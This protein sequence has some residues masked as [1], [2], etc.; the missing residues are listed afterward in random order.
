M[1]AIKKELN[2][3][4]VD[5]E[6]VL[7]EGERL[8][9]IFR[10]LAH[11]PS[12]YNRVELGKSQELHLSLPHGWHKARTWAIFLCPSQATSRARLEVEH[13]EPEPE[14]LWLAGIAGGSFTCYTTV[15]P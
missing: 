13:Q 6:K 14:A 4:K 9:E 15:Q 8:T 1:E 12:G 5:F 7:F 10:L 3:N 2:S 11:S